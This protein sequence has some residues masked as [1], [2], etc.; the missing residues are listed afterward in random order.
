LKVLFVLGGGI[1]I[2]PPRWGG[3]ENLIWQ[4][5]CA[6]ERAG[7]EAAILNDGVK[8]GRAFRAVR[9]LRVIWKARPWQY[10]VVHLHLDS[11][12]GYWNAV[13]R[14]FPFVLV[15]STHYGYAAFP[16]KWF[17]S[18]GRAFRQMSR[19]PYLILISH[20]IKKTF[21]RLGCRARMFVLPNGIN[22]AEFRCAPRPTK[23]AIFLGR[24]EPRKKQALLAKALDSHPV[25]CDFAG[26]IEPDTGFK[27][28]NRN[29]RYLGEW[30]RD[31]VR[32][33]L[34][35]YACLVLLSDG[36]GH[37]GV[38]S[39]AMASGLSLV[40]S[41]EAS[42]NLDLSR[43]WIYVVDRDKDNLGDIIATAVRD[44]PN[45]RA[46]IRDY[47]FQNFDWQVIMPQYIAFLQEI[48][49]KKGKKIP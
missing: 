11:M 2:P 17:S 18:Y 25:E 10:D 8:H 19:A 48:L 31:Q 33:D 24:I 28:N 44:N 41:P 16:D 34:T 20:E 12:T 5:K 36:E 22:C 42:H 21:E 27:V 15:V 37:A 26:P 32:R 13:A 49:P 1:P 30:S 14:F 9:K 7:H 47:C 43:D 23:Q 45:Y 38:V 29:T 39:E 46:E 40:L 3:V 6:L 35:E 4:Q